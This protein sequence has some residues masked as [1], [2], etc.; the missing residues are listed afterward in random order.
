M[1]RIWKFRHIYMELSG[2]IADVAGFYLAGE[3]KC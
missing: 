1:R 2:M 3:K